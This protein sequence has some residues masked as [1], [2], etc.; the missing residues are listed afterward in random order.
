MVS[1]SHASKLINFKEL[2]ANQIKKI[3]VGDLIRYFSNQEFRMGGLV[4][5]V[6]YPDYIVLANYSKNVTW[7]VQ[8]KQPFLRLWIKTKEQMADEREQARA[9]YKKSQQSTS[10]REYYV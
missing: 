4:K 7:S 1:K 9:L 8:L 6:K 2:K 5:F 3:K 10:G